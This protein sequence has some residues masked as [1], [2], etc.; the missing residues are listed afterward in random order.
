MAA[1][2]KKFHNKI[3]RLLIQRFAGSC[4]TLLDLAC[5]RGGDLY[6]WIDCDIKYVRG[7]DIAEDEVGATTTSD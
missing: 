7:Y 3:K 5:G 4:S 2:L 1:P 6:K